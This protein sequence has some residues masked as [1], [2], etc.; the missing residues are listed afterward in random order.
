MVVRPVQLSGQT[1][2]SASLKSVNCILL[3]IRINIRKKVS[4]Q[5]AQT[6]SDTGCVEEWISER[7]LQQQTQ[8][9]Q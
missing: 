2:T 3:N 1:R 7:T 8:A 4:F 5:F 6:E 9:G